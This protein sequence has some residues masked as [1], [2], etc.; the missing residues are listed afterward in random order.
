M[1]DVP[2]IGTGEGQRSRMKNVYPF[3]KSNIYVT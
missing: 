3:S 1:E 2:E